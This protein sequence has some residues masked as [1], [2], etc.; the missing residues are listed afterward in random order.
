MGRPRVY[1]KLLDENDKCI[2]RWFLK[3]KRQYKIGRSEKADLTVKHFSISKKHAIL[4]V[5][6]SGFLKIR[7]KNSQNG[8][9]ANG[10]S[11]KLSAGVSVKIK[12]GNHFTLGACDH[13]IQFFDTI[14]AE[15]Y[16]SKWVAKG[17]I[18]KKEISEPSGEA[19]SEETQEEVTAKVRDRSRSK[20]RKKAKM[21]K[22]SKKDK[23]EKKSKSKSKKEE[24]PESTGGGAVDE[25]VKKLLL[26]SSHMSPE[27]QRK[28]LM[29][30]GVKQEAIH[31]NYDLIEADKE[32]QK[33]KS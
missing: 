29:M 3:A 20:D 1:I 30:M 18:T 31:R 24:K 7:D 9:F 27:S 8:V 26:S 25:K 12:Q 15:D 6:K 4:T 13:K 21:D 17:K 19:I 14:S 10:S 16:E 28:F 2:A 5:S 33:F 32:A 23:K 22:K 11:K